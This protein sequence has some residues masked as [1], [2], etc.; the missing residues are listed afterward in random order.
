MYSPDAYRELITLLKQQGY[1]FA[2]F[3]DPVHESGSKLAYLR[4][5]IDYS[6]AWAADFARID[7]ELGA[8][9]M[10]CFQLRSPLYNLAS[11]QCR[12][13]VDAVLAAGHR[14]GLH[15]TILDVAGASEAELARAIAADLAAARALI[16]AIAPVFSWHNPSLVPD[17]AERLVD[18]EVPGLVNLY[19]RRWVRETRYFSDSNWRHS[20]AEWQE[21]ARAGH[22]RVQLLFH[23][24]QWMARG[25]DMRDVLARTYVQLISEAEAEFSTNHVYRQ[26]HPGGLPSR[27]RQAIRRLVLP[28]PS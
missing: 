6:P 26:M 17:L 11:R 4:H 2:E 23:P 16:P 24:F 27:A 19:G 20:I 25:R 22:A 5:D 13:S 12:A 21:I 14:V 28:D 3:A 10:F 1:D 18:F 15:F 9:A 7:A 8:H